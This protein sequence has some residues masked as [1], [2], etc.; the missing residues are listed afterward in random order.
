[1]RHG[2]TPDSDEETLAG[3]LA[4]ELEPPARLEERVVAAL[5]AEG[6]LR[7][8][9]R[10]WTTRDLPAAAAVFLLGLTLGAYLSPDASSPADSG[11]R[12]L[13]L[14]YEGEPPQARPGGADL[15]REYGAWAAGLRRS[16]R[17]VTGDRLASE[18]RIGVNGADA[19][20]MDAAL[21]G[22]FILGADSLEEATRLAAESPHARHGGRIVLRAI[23]TP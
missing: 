11:P 12:F 5:R 19:G 1:M 4:P 15:A 7:P 21:Q 20:S 22:F 13:L 3:Q 23:D 17:T 6:A 14:L 10:R 2:R 16:G 9:P 8:A 18:P